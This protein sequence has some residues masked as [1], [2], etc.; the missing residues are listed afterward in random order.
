MGLWLQDIFVRLHTC[1]VETDPGLLRFRQ[2]AKSVLAVA[3]AL[4]IFEPFSRAAALFAAI[5]A[6]FL[7]QCVDSGPRRR[8]QISMAVTAAAIMIMMPLGSALH[9]HR[10]AEA[11]LLIFW[12]A[13][14]NYARRF[15]KGNGAFALFTFTQ[16]L[17]ATALP[18]SPKAQFATSS[19]AFAI[20]FVLRFYV[21]PADI[22][23]AFRDAVVVF[24]SRAAQTMHEM[25][26]GTGRGSLD[27]LR[28][29]AQF[30]QNLLIE[31]SELDAGGLHRRIVQEKYEALQSLRMLGQ[32]AAHLGT[33][34]WPAQCAPIHPAIVE[35]ALF[36]L[37]R[38]ADSFEADAVA[39][40]SVRR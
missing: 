9:G 15:L 26:S 40:G 20:A 2:A 6:A 24:S 28:D 17:L 14:V 35:L 16:V 31:H 30:T 21:W 38:I 11:A 37:R 10:A 4:A 7:M 33:G 34:S 19:T 3:I 13:A 23:R 36:R 18:G 39:L 27:A 29:A 12:A 5:D 25:S 8:Q 22:A 32:A 1:L